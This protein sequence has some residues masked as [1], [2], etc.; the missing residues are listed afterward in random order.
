MTAGTA[1]LILGIIYLGVRFEG[2]R[3][4]FFGA[5]GL[6]IGT[7]WYLVD[8]GADKPQTIFYNH[9]AHPA[10]LMKTGDVCPTDRHIWNNW[11]VK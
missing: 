6:S 9:S 1:I 5:L 2:V 10:F 4:L 11:C 7:I 8:F 3:M